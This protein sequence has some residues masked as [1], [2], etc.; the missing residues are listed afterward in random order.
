MHSEKYISHNWL[1]KRSLNRI[2]RQHIDSLRGVVVDLG[3]GIRPY[4]SDILTRAERYIGLD[5]NNTLHGLQADIVA[6][7]NRP[8]PL[9]NEVADCITTFEVIEH[10]A[11]PGIMLSEAFR[12]LRCGGRLLLS[13]PFQWWV[14]EAPWDYQRFTRYGLEYQL[15]KAGFTNIQITPTSGFWA[16]WVLKLNYQLTRLIRGPRL[17]RFVIRAFL[18]PIWWLGQ[19]LAPLMDQ[20]WH[21]ENETAGY[22]VAADKP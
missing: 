11:E 15:K 21:E 5:W 7:L 18:I 19:V 20:Y 16:M 9:R 4:E 12:I 14:H 22:F 8:L 1:I 17:Q 13:A 2:V 3:C 10:L 6:D